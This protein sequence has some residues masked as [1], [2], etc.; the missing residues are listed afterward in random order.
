MGGDEGSS[1]L[2]DSGEG[3]RNAYQ[4]ELATLNQ[5]STTENL[6]DRTDPNLTRLE[7]NH[8]PDQALIASLEARYD[9]VVAGRDGPGATGGAMLDELGQEKDGTSL[10]ISRVKQRHGRCSS[11]DLLLRKS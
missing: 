2:D 11:L 1:H 6:H 3:E 9:A 5:Y 8:Q 4:L 10:A 7:G